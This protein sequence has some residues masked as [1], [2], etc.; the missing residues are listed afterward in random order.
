MNTTIE[1][2]RT[3]LT[4]HR[5]R[6]PAVARESGMSLCWIRTFVRGGFPNPT[7]RRI[8]QLQHY[9]ATHAPPTEDRTE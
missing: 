4:A 1:T 7:L 3:A 2:L 6:Y 9:L 8:E 5:G